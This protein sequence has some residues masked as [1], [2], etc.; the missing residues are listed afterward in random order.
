MKRI[1]GFTASSVLFA[2]ATWLFPSKTDTYAQLFKEKS[3]KKSPSGALGAEGFPDA[4]LIQVDAN[5][6]IL[7]SDPTNKKVRVIHPT[8][9]VTTFGSGGGEAP[10]R[11]EGGGGGTYAAGLSGS[12]TYGGNSYDAYTA[13]N[14]N[15]VS[16]GSGIKKLGKENEVS[17]SPNTSKAAELSDTSNL[18]LGT[19]RGLASLGPSNGSAGFGESAPTGGSQE[20]PNELST[21]SSGSSKTI[22]APQGVPVSSDPENLSEG[23]LVLN[24]N[25]T[26]PVAPKADSDEPDFIPMT[27]GGSGNGKS[28]GAKNQQSIQPPDRRQNAGKAE[29]AAKNAIPPI[30]QQADDEKEKA[31]KEREKTPPNEGKAQEHDSKAAALMAQAAAMAAAMA[32][33]NN[34]KNKAGNDDGGSASQP[35]QIPVFSFGNPEAQPAER[36]APVQVWVPNPNKFQEN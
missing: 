19:G 34:A 22:E 25:S 35:I 7:I 3:I 27:L 12:S 36:E 17:A 11:L 5:G 6:N 10:F 26:P 13:P 23:D 2:G 29:D 4:S 31:K 20:V 32:G 24:N 14:G 28:D 1:W 30:M 21:N 8:G 15:S 33:N 16:S 9:A 18:G